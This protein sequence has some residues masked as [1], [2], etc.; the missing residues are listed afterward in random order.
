MRQMCVYAVLFA[1]VILAGSSRAAVYHVST[2]GSDE[3]DGTAPE[4]A[5]R[6]LDKVNAATLAPGDSV[7]F[8][9]GDVWRGQLR[10]QSG[11]EN[12][13]VTYG[14]YGSG[15]KPL[16][17]GSVRL[18]TPDDWVDEGGSIWITRE[19]APAGDDLLPKNDTA[20]PND[21]WTIYNESGAEARLRTSG[22]SLQ[23]ECIKTGTKGSDTQFYTRAFPIE[24]GKLYAL[25]FR[26]TCTAP[27]TIA[28]PSLMQNKAPWGP[29]ASL[30]GHSTIALDPEPRA[31]S[32]YYRST[33]TADD[34]RITFFLGTALPTD[35]VLSIES[36][37]LRPCEAD[38]YLSRDV[39]NIIF[40]D[41]AVC[42][43]KVWEP[44]DLD[45]Q[46]EYW[47]DEARHIV[48]LFS[49]SCPATFYS[50][51]EC[52]I[53]DHIIDQSNCHF[54]TYE[55]LALKYGSAHGIGGGNTHHIVVRDCDFG[56]IGGGDQMGGDKTVRFGNGIEFWGT[57]HDCLVERCRLWEIYDA[58]LTNQSSGPLTPQY[59]IVYRNNVIWNSEYS[60][61]YW[62][63]PEESETHHIYFENNTCVNAGG[64]WGHSQ[65]PDPSGRHLCFY[66]SPARAH[67]IYIRNNIF[68]EALGNAFYAP[69]WTREAIDALVM[70]HNCWL[71]STGDMI[72]F[73]DKT[74]T[75]ADFDQ[76][77]KDYGKEPHSIV[78]DPLFVDRAKNNFRITEESPCRGAGMD[79][80]A[81]PGA[82]TTPAEQQQ[83]PDIG[84][85][86]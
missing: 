20:R 46:G 81:A 4:H 19:P 58:A 80:G 37:S 54:V 79:T 72:A 56:Y 36:I 59:N 74:Y 70:D 62:N 53:R 84:A 38:K 35:A 55:N 23:I 7:L 13:S 34:A 48:K 8:R 24:I 5:W 3:N 52:A 64:G 25:S 30:P 32:C 66:S 82:E 73:K 17:L 77:R 60:F 18:N 69:S 68:C 83:K 21:A 41:E 10:S 6:T 67:D 39:G 51:I 27:A 65:R 61:E 22:E 76:Y 2:S 12:G 44:Q 85:V 15:P 16:F 57:A 45:T 75:M 31:V 14:A 26:A 78:G 86:E 1:S 9:R 63:R 29:Y 71:Q 33:A 49:A 11:N 50:D 40:N 47:Y 42:G 43:V 28:V